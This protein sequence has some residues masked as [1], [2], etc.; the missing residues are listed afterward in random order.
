MEALKQAAEAHD[1]EAVI[2]LFASDMIL[3]ECQ[4]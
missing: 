4:E 3:L 1:R 2:A